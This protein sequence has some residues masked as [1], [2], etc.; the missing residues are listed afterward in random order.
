VRRL[1]IA[2]LTAMTAWLASVACSDGYQGEAVGMRVGGLAHFDVV[3]ETLDFHCGSFDCHG[4]MGRNLRLYGVSGR[5]LAP[6]DVPCGAPTTAAEVEADY[7][8][9]AGLE[10]EVLAE[11]FAS[12]GKS[13]ERLTLVRKARG[14]EA[15][16]GGKVFPAGS[17]GDLCLVSW[18]SGAPELVASCNN[19]LRDHP[20]C[21]GH[22]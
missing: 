3:A 8:S 9:A 20:S 2:T 4:G 18:V 21:A 7:R 17:D 11:V 15:H 10:P 16:R 22:N 6:G 5:R 12:G 14:A 13:P 1:S 19:S